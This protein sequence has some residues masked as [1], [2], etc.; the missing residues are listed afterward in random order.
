MRYC[1][2][3]MKCLVCAWLRVSVHLVLAGI[4]ITLDMI[5]NLFMPEVAIF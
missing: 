2:I 5:I 1:V 3:N 4:I